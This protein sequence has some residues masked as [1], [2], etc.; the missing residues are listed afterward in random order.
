MSVYMLHECVY[1]NSILLLSGQLHV[2]EVTINA[3]CCPVIY[4]LR[5][6]L[7]LRGI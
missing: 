4:I 1:Q 6:P 3:C 5:E 7:A 2:I